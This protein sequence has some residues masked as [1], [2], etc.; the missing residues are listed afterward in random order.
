MELRHVPND[1]VFFVKPPVRT[2]EPNIA[3]FMNAF[4]TRAGLVVCPRGYV[5][6]LGYGAGIVRRLM[7]YIVGWGVGD[8]PCW[9]EGTGW[10]W[11]QG[12]C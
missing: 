7:E 3:V 6:V 9:E 1:A 4:V 2:F 8:A 5:P 10:K 11:R 12:R